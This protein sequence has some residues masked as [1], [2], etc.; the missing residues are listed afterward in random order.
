MKITITIESADA[1]GIREADLTA[2]KNQL[3][4]ATRRLAGA[5]A[6]N[7]PPGPTP[8]GTGESNMAGPALQQL[9]DQ[10]TAT[11]GVIDSAVVLINGFAVRI[12]TA[13]DTALAGGAT[14]EE[15]ATMI[16]NEVA[17]MKSSSDALAA[18]V[19]ANQ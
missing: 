18:A 13:I 12:H 16:N 11:R 7:S 2:I 10:V 15:L 6:A 9:T 4:E 1:G 17:A 14:A 19:V 5:V 3:A 8:P